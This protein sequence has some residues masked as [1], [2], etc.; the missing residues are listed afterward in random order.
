MSIAKSIESKLSLQLRPSFLEI[1]DDSASHAG[2][3]AMKGLKAKET[4]F[5]VKIV[6][7]KFLNLSKLK[8]HRMVY[9]ILD[10]EF[11]NGLHALNISA[12]TE[13]EFKH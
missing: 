11:K 2:H 12:K 5:Q 13:D 8:R 6:S 3:A 9:G 1:V 7:D 10:E 4:H